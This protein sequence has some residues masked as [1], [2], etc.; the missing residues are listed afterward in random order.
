MIDHEYA[1]AFPDGTAV[2]KIELRYQRR[3]VG[4]GNASGLK[5]R[6]LSWRLRR[7]GDSRKLQHTGRHHGVQVL[8]SWQREGTPASESAS[9]IAVR[10]K[11]RPVARESGILRD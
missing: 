2:S 3:R 10:E 8:R 11:A 6:R 9:E 1:D 4:Y 7:S 5:D